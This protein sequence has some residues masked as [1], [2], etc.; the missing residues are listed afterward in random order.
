[1]LVVYAFTAFVNTTALE[2]HWVHLGAGLAEALLGGEVLGL[3][4]R[5][6]VYGDALTAVRVEIRAVQAF[7]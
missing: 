6:S 2:A 7:G 1:M 5:T 3:A 4:E